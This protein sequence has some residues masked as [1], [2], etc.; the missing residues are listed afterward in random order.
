MRAK[1]PWA[2]TAGEFVGLKRFLALLEGTADAAFAIDA[3]GRI[4]GWN[5]AA[6]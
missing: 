2:L 1:L 3:T 6:V 5:K 4:S